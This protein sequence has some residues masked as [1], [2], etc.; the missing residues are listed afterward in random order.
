VERPRYFRNEELVDCEF[1]MIVEVDEGAFDNFAHDFP[2]R[3]IYVRD[4][5]RRL[6]RSIDGHNGQGPGWTMDR[7]ACPG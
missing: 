4:G 3:I 7:G 6:T 5:E 2:V 1:G